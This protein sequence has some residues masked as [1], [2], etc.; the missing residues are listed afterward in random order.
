M[1]TN[2]RF[3]C[4]D[5]LS[6]NFVELGYKLQR[7]WVVHRALKFWAVIAL[8]SI[9]WVLLASGSGYAGGVIVVP[10]RSLTLWLKR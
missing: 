7:W 6:W 5:I 9:S 1:Y 8:G 4:I 3:L 10:V 2:E